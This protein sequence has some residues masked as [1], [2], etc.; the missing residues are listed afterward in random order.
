MRTKAA[1]ERTGGMYSEA[2]FFRKSGLR[3]KLW[4]RLR[5]HTSEWNYPLFFRFGRRTVVGIAMRNGR[6]DETFIYSALENGRR[7]C[8]TA[9]SLENGLNHSEAIFVRKSGLRRE[10]KQT[11]DA[12]TRTYFRMDLSSLFRFGGRSSVG[13]MDAN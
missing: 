3:S 4:T 1:S 5:G 10:A 8:L 12:V 2:I 9:H 11:M 6:T 7:F 13:L